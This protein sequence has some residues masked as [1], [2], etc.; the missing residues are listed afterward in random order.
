[1]ESV[2]AQ[3][4]C[5]CKDSNVWDRFSRFDAIDDNGYIKKLGQSSATSICWIFTTAAGEQG[6]HI[7]VHPRLICTAAEMPSYTQ[8]MRERK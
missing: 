3:S 1:M 5:A 2:H 6:L 4:D 7:S 8:R